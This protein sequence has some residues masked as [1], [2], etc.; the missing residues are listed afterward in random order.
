M[1]FL[2]IILPLI[3]ISDSCPAVKSANLKINQ[4]SGNWDFTVEEVDYKDEN[5]IPAISIKDIMI[6]YELEQIDILKI[7]I[8]GAEKELFEDNYDYWL[9]KTRVLVIELHDGLKYGASKSF[10]SAVSKFDFRMIK[11]DENL[12]F[13]FK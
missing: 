7:D 13:Y 3:S 11:K 10:F 6:K 5:T 2:E 12:V 1:S 9:K 4:N 8:E